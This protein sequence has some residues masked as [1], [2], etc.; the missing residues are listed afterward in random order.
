M[1]QDICQTAEEINIMYQEDQ[2]KS[3]VFSQYSHSPYW[4]KKEMVKTV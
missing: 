3:H 1:Y 4:Q 2:S